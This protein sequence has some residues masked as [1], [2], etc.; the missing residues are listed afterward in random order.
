M[1]VILD[2]FIWVFVLKHTIILALNFQR[3]CSLIKVEIYMKGLKKGANHTPTITNESPP[4]PH[5]K[6]EVNRKMCRWWVGSMFAYP[7]QPY[8]HTHNFGW[9]NQRQ[10]CFIFINARDNQIFIKATPNMPNSRFRSTL[11]LHH[12]PLFLYN[13]YLVSRS[14][15]Y[16]YF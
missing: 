4:Q 7:M 2:D 12:P 11:I 16:F 8:N 15:I 3:H 9:L 14:H 13:T 6:A 5:R 1:L 10:K